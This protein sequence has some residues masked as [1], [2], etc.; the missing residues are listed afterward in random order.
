MSKDNLRVLMIGNSFSICVCKHFPAIAEAEGVRLKLASL[1]IGGC[2]LRRHWENV[3]QAEADPEFRPYGL[4][5]CGFDESDGMPD[6]EVANANELLACGD[7]DVVTVQQA[8]HESWDYAN[9][10]PFGHQLVEYIRRVSPKSEVVIQQTWA[11]RADDPRIR[12]GGEWGFDQAGMADRVFT[13]YDRFAADE[14]IR[15]QIPTGRA[16]WISRRLDPAPF[17]PYD[18]TELKACRWPDLPSQASDV[19]GKLF[20]RKDPETGEMTICRD[21]IHL[22]VRG[23][24]LQGLVWYGYLFG[25]DPAAVSYVSS[26]VGASDAQFLKNCAR[27]ALAQAQKRKS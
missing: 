1:Y 5:L 17:R 10:Q 20:W 3:E 24:Y 8:S 25:R 16:V 2:P 6:R 26:E 11:Y 14:G 15:R 27:E 21:S 13:A 7:W 23:E 4:T 12:P 9:Y 22:N 18:E 19:V